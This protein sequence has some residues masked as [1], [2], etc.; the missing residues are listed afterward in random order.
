MGEKRLSG[1]ALISIERQIV[2]EFDY[3][4]VVDNFVIGWNLDGGSC[5]N[6]ELILVHKLIKHEVINPRTPRGVRTNP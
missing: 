3:Y 5:C 1:L 6:V 4:E 2:W